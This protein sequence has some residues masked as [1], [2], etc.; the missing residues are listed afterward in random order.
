MSK[1]VYLKQIQG[2]TFAVKGN[3]G[4]W[5][6]IDNTVESG[7][8]AGAPSSKELVLYALAGC[9]STDVVEILRKKRAPMTDYEVHIKASEREEHPRIFTTVHIEYIIYG[10]GVKKED[11]ERAI[12]LS[13]TKYCS[14]SA[15][16][17]ASVT[18]THSYRIE[19][20]RKS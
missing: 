13:I 17:G 2:A 8:S 14:V 11:V 4:H 7:G 16:L 6:T 15:I 5:I 20:S 1:E 9:T 18:I 10:N 3:T 19:P 12:E